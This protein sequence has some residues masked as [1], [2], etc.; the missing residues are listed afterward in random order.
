MNNFK[1]LKEQ[2]FYVFEKLLIYVAVHEEEDINPLFN[3]CY[4]MNVLGHT[5]AEFKISLLPNS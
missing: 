4:T 2:T 5:L 1:F 3:S